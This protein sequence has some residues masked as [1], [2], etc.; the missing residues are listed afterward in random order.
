MGIS[1]SQFHMWP[2]VT[3]RLSPLQVTS[4]QM[5]WSRRVNREQ[6]LLHSDSCYEA[7]GGLTGEEKK[8]WMT[9]KR[10]TSLHRTKENRTNWHKC[11][12]VNSK[13]P[14][15]WHEQPQTVKTCRKHEASSAW[16]LSNQG[17]CISCYRGEEYADVY[18]KL[19]VIRKNSLQ[20]VI[21]CGWVLET[22]NT[23]KSSCDNR[24]CQ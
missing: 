13:Q 2:W 23:V 22:L 8:V 15:K 5:D 4:V 12:A 17:R 24:M 3:W 1:H 19:C 16:E 11:E 20:E 7:N 10:T 9:D 14:D 18:A 21:I 6:S